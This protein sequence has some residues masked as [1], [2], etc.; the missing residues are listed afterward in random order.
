M[1]EAKVYISG[2][3]AAETFHPGAKNNNMYQI[4]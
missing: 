2:R 4:L 3:S 1:S